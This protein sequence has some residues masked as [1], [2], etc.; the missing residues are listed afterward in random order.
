MAD[1]NDVSLWLGNFSDKEALDKYV[2]VSYTEEGDS[3]PSQFEKDYKL[4]YYDR[5]LIERDWI[6][7]KNKN[8]RELL[9]GF[10]YDEQLIPQ[11]K[12][13]ETIYNSILLVYNYSYNK[14]EDKRISI[15][16]QNYQ[17]NFVG[18]ASY[19]DE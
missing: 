5:D 3:I 15:V 7:V 8:I 10:S 17:I 9:E 6:P 13:Q 11:F 16:N 14:E 1:K 4:G 19:L 18:V 12:N 2:E